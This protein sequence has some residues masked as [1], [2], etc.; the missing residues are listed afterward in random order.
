MMGVYRVCLGVLVSYQTDHEVLWSKACMHTKYS[1]VSNLYHNLSR[2]P[3]RP[4]GALHQKVFRHT[5]ISKF[6]KGAPLAPPT[7]LGIGLQDRYH[8]SFVSVCTTCSK[9]PRRVELDIPTN[10]S[11][12]NQPCWLM[13][14]IEPFLA[15]R[16]IPHF[17]NP[18]IHSYL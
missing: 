15:D 12:H 1:D 18:P 8:A 13:L 3:I 11:D 4:V 7:R 2:S 17:G 9:I 10:S 14:C 6:A 16:V 5:D